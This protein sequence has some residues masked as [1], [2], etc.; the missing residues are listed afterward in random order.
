MK[1]W[2][3]SEEEAPLEFR[4]GGANCRTLEGECL[5]TW[6]WPGEVKFV[7]ICGFDPSHPAVVSFGPEAIYRDQ[8]SDYLR[9][10][11]YTRE[12]YKAN[13][14]YRERLNFTHHYVYRIYPCVRSEA[15]TLVYRQESRSNEAA[16]SMDRARIRCIVKYNG[17]WFSKYRTVQMSIMAEVRVPKEALCYVKKTGSLPLHKEDGTLYPMLTDL[18]PGLN[19]LADIEVGKADCIKLF[20][21]DGKAFGSMYELIHE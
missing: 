12:E 14:G 17:G 3:W 13:S 20:F 15:D 1:K 10:K 19:R 18:M 9:M 7:L 5:L 6:N 11:L 16:V 8:A 2:Q 4:I 21:T